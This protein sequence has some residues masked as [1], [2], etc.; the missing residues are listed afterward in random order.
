MNGDSAYESFLI[1]VIFSLTKI[2]IIGY[3]SNS[4]SG[5]RNSNYYASLRTNGVMTDNG[6]GV[7]RQRRC[8]E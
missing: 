7:V 1:V 2:A 5:Y 8:N 6:K 3:V 4:A